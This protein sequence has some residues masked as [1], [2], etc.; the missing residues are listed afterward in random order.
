[1]LKFKQIAGKERKGRGGAPGRRHS[2]SKGRK[3]GNCTVP[4]SQ[5][6]RVLEGPWEI[7]GKR[8]RQGMRG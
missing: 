8:E 5:D 3:V 2:E 6:L 7:N 1:M 4:E